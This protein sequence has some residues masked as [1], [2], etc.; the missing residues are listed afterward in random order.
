[1]WS[2]PSRREKQGIKDKD[3]LESESGEHRQSE[4][5]KYCFSRR[6]VRVAGAVLQEE[7]LDSTVVHLCSDEGVIATGWRA[8]AISKGLLLASANKTSRA[9][10]YNLVREINKKNLLRSYTLSS[11][12]RNL[13]PTKNIKIMN[14]KCQY[15][16]DSSSDVYR[17]FPCFRHV[18]H[19][20][21]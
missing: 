12:K 1:M 7:L 8:P 16:E 14:Q 15:F 3:P 18:K 19:S 11:Q 21:S 10:G 9:T 13:Y 17:L 4:G 2:F 6:L 5:G 20:R